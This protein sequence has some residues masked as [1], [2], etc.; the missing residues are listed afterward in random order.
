M[1]VH[2]ITGDVSLD[3][4]EHWPLFMQGLG[5]QLKNASTEQSGPANEKASVSKDLFKK[6]V[7][8]F[9][10]QVTNMIVYNK[11]SWLTSFPS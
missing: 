1:Q 8:S 2:L 3:A 7:T 9:V 4:I 5:L 6:L 10:R 11:G